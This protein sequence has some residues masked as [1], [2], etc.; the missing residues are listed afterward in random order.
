LAGG[1]EPRHA[2][3]IKR[4]VARKRHG[5]IGEAPFADGVPRQQLNFVVA[6][7]PLQT[8]PQGID[9]GAFAL[10]ALGELTIEV[11]QMP[12]DT[13]TLVAQAGLGQQIEEVQSAKVLAGFGLVN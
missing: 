3:H 8:L 6:N 11:E 2:V 10:D 13:Q 7:I 5:P 9:A 4:L 1:E 12:R